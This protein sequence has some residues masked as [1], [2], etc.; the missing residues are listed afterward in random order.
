MES[1]GTLPSSEEIRFATI[2]GSHAN[3]AARAIMHGSM[4]HE[5]PNDWRRAI[6][7]GAEWKV[8]KAVVWQQF[9]ELVDMVCQSGNTNQSISKQEDEMQLVNKIRQAC[10]AYGGSGAPK[11]QDV[12]GAVL[13]SR[14]KCGPS[15][16]AIFGFVV[17]FGGSS[18]LLA[19]TQAYVRACG[20]GGRELGQETWATLSQEMKNFPDHLRW[21]HA[22]LKYGFA[23]DTTLTAT[24]AAGKQFISVRIFTY[25]H[26]YVYI[27][28][29]IYINMYIYMYIYTCISIVI[30]VNLPAGWACCSL[31]LFG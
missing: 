26:V 21:R 18:K 29:C 28:M 25:T 23:G 10:T 12:A 9:P 14:P 5:I 30:A 16:P 15:G 20:K 1:N 3:M 17:R 11:W 6:Q 27:Y 2:C 22:L 7:D 19:D 4:V 24:D 31:A 13:R 8:I